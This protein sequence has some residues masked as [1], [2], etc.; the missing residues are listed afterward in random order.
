MSETAKVLQTPTPKETRLI[1]GCRFLLLPIYLGLV[2]CMLFYNIAFFRDLWSLGASFMGEHGEEYLLL[3][4]LGLVDMAMIGSLVV[5]IIIGSYSV[6][7]SEI[8]PEDMRGRA[9]RFIIGLTSGI[10]KVKMGMSL[11]S[12]SSIHL[13]AAFMSEHS[14]WDSILKKL[15][16]HLAFILSA[17]VFSRIEA[18]L[19]PPAVH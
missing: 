12:V 3:G 2:I 15:V 17:F 13:L 14:S 19:H 4:V 9:P 5:M 10:L 16:I 1:L 18:T 6:F 7:V 8:R 11:V